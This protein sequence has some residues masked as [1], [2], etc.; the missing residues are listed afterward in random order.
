LHVRGFR[1]TPGAG[2]KDDNAVSKE[3][4]EEADHEEASS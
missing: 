2:S 4:H 3:D 1:N